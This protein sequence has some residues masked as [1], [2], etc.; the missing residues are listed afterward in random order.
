AEALKEAKS[1]IYEAIRIISGKIGL[2]NKIPIRIQEYINIKGN[3]GSPNP[4][5]I[6]KIIEEKRR[7]IQQNNFM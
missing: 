2:T 3:I 6:M 7:I 5:Q 4:Q 1:D